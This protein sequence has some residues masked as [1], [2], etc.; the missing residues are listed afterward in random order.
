M[1]WRGRR[2]PAWE[3]RQYT[4]YEVIHVGVYTVTKCFERRRAYIKGGLLP[5][6]I[7]GYHYRPRLA[8]FHET[9]SAIVVLYFYTTA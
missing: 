6:K 7:L 2:Y 8:T 5:E 9:I 1:R 3:S 4:H